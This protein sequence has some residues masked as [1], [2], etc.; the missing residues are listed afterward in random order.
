MAVQNS[1]LTSDAQCHSVH[2]IVNS[3][4]WSCLTMSK[5]ICFQHSYIVI[6]EYTQ[7]CLVTGVWWAERQSS[8][9]CVCTGKAMCTGNALCT[10][11]SASENLGSMW[12]YKCQNTRSSTCGFVY[13]FSLKVFRVLAQRNWHVFLINAQYLSLDVE[14]WPQDKKLQFKAMHWFTVLSVLA[15]GQT[16]VLSIYI[17]CTQLPVTLVPSWDKW[18]PLLAAVGIHTHM[19]THNKIKT[20]IF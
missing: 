8:S 19:H 15:E 5:L 9:R 13:L 17:R 11:M 4:Y 2:H 3:N 20:E 10:G 18:H 6:P 1:R 16:L 12:R 7:H 14:V